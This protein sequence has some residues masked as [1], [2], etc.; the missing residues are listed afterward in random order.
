MS[1]NYWDEEDDND[2]VITG[3][4]TENDLQKKLRKKIRAD[5][6]RIKELEE[7]LGSFGF[8]FDNN[9]P[10]AIPQSF[11]FG[12]INTSRVNSFFNLVL[13]N[14]LRAHPPTTMS[15]MFGYISK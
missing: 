4:E 14:I 13:S 5:E 1:N 3:N 2:D 15:G 10:D 9:K 7:K 12:G 8:N 6:K 11:G